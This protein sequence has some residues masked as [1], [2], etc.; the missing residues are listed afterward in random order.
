MLT[1]IVDLSEIFGGENGSLEGFQA[2]L[3]LPCGAG[4]DDDA[5]HLFVGKCP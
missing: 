2:V 5:R 3:E 4:T 1:D